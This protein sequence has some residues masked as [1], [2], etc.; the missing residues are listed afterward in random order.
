M[1]PYKQRVA[2][3][4]CG[5]CGKVRENPN[6]SMC[7]EHAAIE[8]ERARKR[9]EKSK[10]DGKCPSCGVRQVAEGRKRCD[11]CLAASAASQRRTVRRRDKENLCQSCGEPARPGKKTCQTCVDKASKISS[12]RYRERREAGL[13]SYCEQPPVAGSTMCQY[14]LNKTQQ[15][16][17]NLKLE[18]FEAYGGCKCS[19]CEET[20]PDFLEIDHIDGGGRQHVREVVG[21]SGHGL[22]GWLKAN[23]FPPGFRVLCRT[24]NAKAHVEKCRESGTKLTHIHGNT[25]EAHSGNELNPSDTS[26]A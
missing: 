11:V 15:Q 25:K 7:D 14:H 2:D 23:N 26:N 5:K 9:R 10:K 1:S 19:W 8:R 22:R 21:S 20:N 4:L 13:C 16:R 24:C 12:R 3:G 18:V 6:A 17:D